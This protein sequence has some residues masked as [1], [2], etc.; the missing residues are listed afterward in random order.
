MITESQMCV[1]RC[2]KS[3]IFT[4]DLAT[5]PSTQSCNTELETAEFS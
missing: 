1:C 5:I 3:L 4:I 2:Q